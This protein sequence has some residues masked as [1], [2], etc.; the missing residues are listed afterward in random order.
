MLIKALDQAEINSTNKN[1]INRG[2]LK[3]QNIYS[4][5]FIK[6]FT[7][8]ANKTS[9]EII[10]KVVCSEF[11]FKGLSSVTAIK[12]TNLRAQFAS[13]A[14]YL[15]FVNNHSIGGIACSSGVQTIKD[16]TTSTIGLDTDLFELE[17]ECTC[18]F[19]T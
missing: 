15:E 6:I 2:Y 5:N 7:K 19:A 12:V 16:C 13:N 9:V 3:F 14:E 10:G 4:E 1:I 11:G 17:I 18:K 8:T